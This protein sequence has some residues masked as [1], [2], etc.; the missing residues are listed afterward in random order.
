MGHFKLS[1]ILR[2]KDTQIPATRVSYLRIT[3]LPSSWNPFMSLSIN[4]QSSYVCQK[5]LWN[6][7]PLHFSNTTSF[8][9]S[10]CSSQSILV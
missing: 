1:Y 7:S 5:C 8:L 3:F 9:C 4:S 6:H 2:M 10:Q